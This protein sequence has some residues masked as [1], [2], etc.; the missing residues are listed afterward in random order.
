MHIQLEV[1]TE[2][3]INSLSDLANFKQVME[4]LNMKINKSKLARDMGVDRRTID[5]YLNGF[6][7]KQSVLS[8]LKLMSSTRLLPASYQKI[9]SR[10]FIID[11]IFGSI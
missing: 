8:H 2:F 1:E 9:L 3:K 5:K 10:Y 4:H 7:P 6:I 11:A